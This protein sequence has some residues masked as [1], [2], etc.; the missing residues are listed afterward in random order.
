MATPILDIVSKDLAYKLQDPVSSGTTNG[1]RISAADRGCQFV[2]F[3]IPSLR[4]RIESGAPL[5]AG[6]LP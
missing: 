1:V 2:A 3:P 5:P 6:Y 4:E